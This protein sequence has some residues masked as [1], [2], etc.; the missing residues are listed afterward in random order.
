MHCITTTTTTKSSSRTL[1]A[2]TKIG[3]G[4][5]DGRHLSTQRRGT[6]P[7]KRP[8]LT[9]CAPGVGAAASRQPSLIFRLH[10]KR[11]WI[12]PRQRNITNIY[13]FQVKERK[14]EGESHSCEA[15]HWTSFFF[16]SLI[17]FA[18][19]QDTDDVVRL[20]F[21]SWVNLK[22]RLTTSWSPPVSCF[23]SADYRADSSRLPLPV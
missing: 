4:P 10:K 23:T 22:P 19:R 17:V 7:V 2:A 3:H 1:R 9:T 11:L 18:K 21:V 5:L 20:T 14:T 12:E 15:K 8:Q 13:I 16:P 6:A